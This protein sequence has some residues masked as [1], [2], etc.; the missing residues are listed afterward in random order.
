MLFN[1]CDEELHEVMLDG[2]CG[3]VDMNV[4][5]DMACRAAE[6]DDERLGTS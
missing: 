3:K 2:R 6:V 5:E 1:S 4:D